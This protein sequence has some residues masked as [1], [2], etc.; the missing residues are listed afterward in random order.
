[1]T[2][3]KKVPFAS[4]IAITCLNVIPFI[5]SQEV[6]QIKGELVGCPVSVIFDG[7]TRLREAMAIV[8]RFV[9]TVLN[10]HQLLVC[11]LL[12]TKSTDGGGNCLRDD[13]HSFSSIWHPLRATP[14]CY[15]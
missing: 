3:L 4:L 6:D 7:T 10:V 14:C 2:Y 8:V 1:M 5:L 9:D 12:L 13:Q 11:L 15:A